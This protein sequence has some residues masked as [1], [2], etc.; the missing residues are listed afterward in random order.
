MPS[1]PRSHTVRSRHSRAG[2]VGPVHAEQDA[3]SSIKGRRA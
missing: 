3:A 2:S 1:A